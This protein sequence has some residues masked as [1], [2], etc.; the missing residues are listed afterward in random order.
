MR[1]MTITA[2][3]T[4]AFADLPMPSPR[5][6]EV[7]VQVKR[8]G[9]CGSDLSTFRGANP[10][11]TLPRIPGHEVAGVVAGHG[12]NVPSTAPPLGSTVLCLPYTNCGEC[13]AC[14]QGRVNCC[15]FNQT[16]GVQRDGAM[17]EFICLPASKV[18]APSGL[19]LRELASV[20]PLTVG[21]HAVIRG[22]VVAGDVV[23]VL[24]CGAIGL[25]AIASAAVRGAVVI[26][27]DIDDAKLALAQRA[28][29]THTIN[30]T[31]ED[32]H[33][34]LQRLTDG[35]GPHVM[36]EAVGHP[37]TFRAA[38]DEVCWAGRV[39]YVGYAA[40]PVQ[41]ETRHF[42]HKELDILGSRNATHADFEAVINLVRSGVFPM[43]AFI[44]QEVPFAD[45]D[46]AL[47]AWA[48]DPS[49]VTKIHVVF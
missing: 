30:S 18:L 20:E 35:H 13:A 15:R 12:P 34:A 33:A 24:G 38:V 16:L 48:A 23:G 9:Y 42:V 40:A 22:R 47:H 5:E 44:T 41:Y 19:S 1:A 2:A 25:G 8:V 31:R 14:R 7:L 6:G 45:A 10:L 28:G 3:G 4:T 21:M 46:Q 49:R 11:V 43:D 17:T 29:A 36:L 39:V 32:L 26:A 37:S 27:I